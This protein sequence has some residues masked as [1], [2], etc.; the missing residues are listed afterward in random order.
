MKNILLAV[1]MIALASPGWTQVNKTDSSNMKSYYLKKSQSQKKT[2]FILLGVGLGCA[3]VGGILAANPDPDE[4]ID[5]NTIAGGG[6]ILGG[7]VTALASIPFF[8][9]SSGNMKKASSFSAGIKVDKAVPDGV[10]RTTHTYYPA[11]SFKVS[12]K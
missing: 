9:S 11:L 8:I 2:G 6:L 5:D 7:G 3:A 1:C 10:F 4:I 12:L